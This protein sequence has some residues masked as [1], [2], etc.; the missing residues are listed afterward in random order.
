MWAADHGAK[1]INLSLGGPEADKI[2]QV[3]VDHATAKGALVVVAAGNDGTATTQYPAAYPNALAVA[4]TDSHGALTLFSSYGDWVDVA[5]PGVAITS[6]YLGTTYATG[7]AGTSFASP[8]VAGVAALVRTQNPTWTPAK[9]AARI[10]GSATDIG[11]P[12]VNP[13]DGHGLIDAGA[14]VG[15]PHTARFG[16]E[17]HD[18]E[19]D[20]PTSAQTLDTTTQHRTGPGDVDWFRTGPTDP[21]AGAGWTFEVKPSASDPS[22]AEWM[23]PRL[24][25]YD[26]TLHL[27]GTSTAQL[28]QAGDVKVSLVAP[29]GPLFVQVSNLNPGSSGYT[30]AGAANGTT[31]SPTVAGPEAWVTDTAPRR[32]RASDVPTSRRTPA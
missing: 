11:P 10:E 23:D 2:L 4:A 3:A 31:G 17:F 29:G 6:T 20:T 9:I 1:V 24:S 30:L 15:A 12:G 8:I 28:D 22:F 26:S 5:A 16:G 13:Y 7:G 25:V 19:T 14:A 27:L 18:P 32:S 21:V